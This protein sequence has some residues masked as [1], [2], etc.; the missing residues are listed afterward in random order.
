MC[1]PCTIISPP[2]PPLLGTSAPQASFR[3][4]QPAPCWT[5]PMAGTRETEAG[6][7]R[8]DLTLP[9]YFLIIP[10]CRLLCRV[11]VVATCRFSNTHTTSLISS[12]KAPGS[13]GQSTLSSD[14]SVVSRAPPGAQTLAVF[15]KVCVQL[16]G[17]LPP[18][19]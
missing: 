4:Y 15:S 13:G 9:V 19:L 6:G 16:S 1:P 8:K 14:R 12:S 11:M 5:L 18:R 10:P 7:G 2:N 3:F 17:A